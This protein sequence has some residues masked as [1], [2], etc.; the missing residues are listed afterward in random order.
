[1]KINQLFTKKV[2]TEIVLKLLECFG[3]HDFN[4]KK[5]FCKYD[6][7]QNN[8]VQKVNAL[9]PELESFYLPCKAR[10]Y[11]EDMTEK[12]EITVLKQIL[13]L[14]GYYLAS[15][16]KNINNKKI[17]FYQMI[18][19]KDKLQPQHMKRYSITNILNFS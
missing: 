17:I 18:N 13:R 14:H 9:K 11:L 19:E 10:V 6:L 16:E 8:T 1:M 7:M 12:R 2:D 3:I 15:K 5:T 4:E